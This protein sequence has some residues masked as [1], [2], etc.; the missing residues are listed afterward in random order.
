MR[1]NRI[2]TSHHNVDIQTVRADYKEYD[3]RH[4]PAVYLKDISMSSHLYVNSLNKQEF[5]IYLEALLRYKYCEVPLKTV[6]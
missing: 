2:N 4:R 1:I 5:Q 3:D 6:Q